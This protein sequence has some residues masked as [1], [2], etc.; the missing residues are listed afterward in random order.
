MT[1]REF[2]SLRFSTR[3]EISRGKE[4]NAQWGIKSVDSAYAVYCK[5]CGVTVRSGCTPRCLQ[6][7]EKPIKDVKYASR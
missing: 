4:C 7:V 1:K 5:T 6:D 3:R 2:D